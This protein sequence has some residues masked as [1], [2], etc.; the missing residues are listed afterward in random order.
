M[1]IKTTWIYNYTPRKIM[2]MSVIG[3]NV[4]QLEL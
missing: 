2:T 1:Q 4:K 3:K